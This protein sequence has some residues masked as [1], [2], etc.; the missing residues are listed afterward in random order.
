MTISLY[1]I[2]TDRG[3]WSFRPQDGT[4]P[5]RVRVPK[6][7]VLRE[8]RGMGLG[9]SVLLFVPS[10]DDDML[11]GGWPANQVMREAQTGGRFALVKTKGRERVTG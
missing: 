1:P 8:V 6:G 9:M 2:C 4:S 7:S 3:I 10:P 11:L 5:L